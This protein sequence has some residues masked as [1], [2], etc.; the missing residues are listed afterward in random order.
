MKNENYKEVSKNN[1]P[2]TKR[3]ELTQKRKGRDVNK[4]FNGREVCLQLDIFWIL[5]QSLLLL[6]GSCMEYWPETKRF[7][8]KNRNR[9]D[10]RPVSIE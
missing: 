2:I 5:Y 6:H 9:D 10:G 3:Y 4:T 1:N 8:P 7:P